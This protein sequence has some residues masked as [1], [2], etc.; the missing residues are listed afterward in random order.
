MLKTLCTSIYGSIKESSYYAIFTSHSVC[1]TVAWETRKWVMFV[2]D[3]GSTVFTEITAEYFQPVGR[4]LNQTFLLTSPSSTV[5]WV[6]SNQPDQSVQHLY[7]GTRVVGIFVP[8]A[9]TRR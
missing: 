4:L 1:A 8:A 9:P 3:E 2:Y 5:G 6:L 7:A